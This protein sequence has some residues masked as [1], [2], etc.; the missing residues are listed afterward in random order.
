MH[1][2]LIAIGGA[3][4]A[5]LRYFIAS[6]FARYLCDTFPCGTLLV[7]ILGSLLIT[8][9]M[10][11][12]NYGS[13]DPHYRYFLVIGFLGSFTTL[14]SVTYDTL[15]LIKD[16]QLLLAFLNLIGNFFVSLLAG[17]AGF[18]LAKIFFTRAF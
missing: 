4:G 14:S 2:I 15:S 7:N 13:L 18:L 1:L 11:L 16:K 8:F 5:L 3:I 10:S 12:F 17:I 9:F 6:L